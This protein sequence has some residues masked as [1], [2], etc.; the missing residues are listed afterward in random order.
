MKKTREEGF[1]L[2]ELSIVL[3]IIGMILSVG[4]GLMN[5]FSKQTKI[6]REKANLS[7]IKHS[8]TSYALSRGKLPAPHP[9]NELPYVEL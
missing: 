3:V 7:A 9:P 4:V 2:V 6:T 5:N 8:L 1:S